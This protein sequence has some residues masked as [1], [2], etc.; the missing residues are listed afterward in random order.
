M[1]KKRLGLNPDIFC[2]EK[3][4]CDEKLAENLPT[5]RLHY[6]CEGAQ[7]YGMTFLQS[8]KAKMI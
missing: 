2:P 1:Y 7:T 5:T 6:A 4:E 3:T 8:L